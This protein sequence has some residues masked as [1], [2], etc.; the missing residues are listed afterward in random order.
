MLLDGP[1]KRMERAQGT[2]KMLSGS[3]PGHRVR[4]RNYSFVTVWGFTARVWAFTGANASAVRKVARDT[5]LLF[6]AGSALQLLA[7]F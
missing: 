6:Y 3:D 1:N 2:T 7:Y 5:V 4:I